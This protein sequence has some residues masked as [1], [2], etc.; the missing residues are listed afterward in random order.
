[1]TTNEPAGLNLVHRP[2]RLRGNPILRSMVEETRLS[3]K[4]FIYPMFD[5]AEDNLWRGFCLTS[6]RVGFNIPKS[7]AKRLFSKTT[8]L[9]I[10]D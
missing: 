9:S 7:H 2:R 4:D 10:L 3:P 6:D 8:S 1:M 5:Q